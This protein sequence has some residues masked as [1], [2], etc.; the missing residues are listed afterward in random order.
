MNDMQ[1]Q[2]VII[3]EI[4]SSLQQDTNILRSCVG[5]SAI[6]NQSSESHRPIK[7]HVK[8]CGLLHYL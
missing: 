7:A 8:A 2:V 5:G 4:K 3:A 1:L 6:F